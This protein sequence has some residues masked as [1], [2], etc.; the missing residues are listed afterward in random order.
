M[1]K[2]GKEKQS[3]W[4]GA[5]TIVR[6]VACIYNAGGGGKGSPTRD[7]SYEVACN[8][9]ICCMHVMSR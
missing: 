6:W 3:T 4:F 9:D 7:P 2:C 1:V 8:H 5:M